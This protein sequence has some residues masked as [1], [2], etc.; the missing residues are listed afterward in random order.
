M[1]LMGFKPTTSRTIGSGQKDN[2]SNSLTDYI[3]T[4][5]VP[6]NRMVLGLWVSTVYP[7][8]TSCTPPALSTHLQMMLDPSQDPFVAHSPTTVCLAPG[9]AWMSPGI[10]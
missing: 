3:L 9:R 8:P 4:Q 6:K 10:Q 7:I 2:N 5:R 1:I